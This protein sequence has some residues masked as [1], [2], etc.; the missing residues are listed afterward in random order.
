M[1][2]R[3]RAQQRDALKAMAIPAYQLK[4][5]HSAESDADKTQAATTLSYHYRLGPFYLTAA[6]PLPVQLP[7]WLEDCC[8]LLDCRPVAVKAASDSAMV[9]DYQQC[10]QQLSSAAGKREF[11]HNI[12]QHITQQ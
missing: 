9:W 3:W 6:E 11:W 10:Q 1:P 7:R 5:L 8:V 12:R 4:Q 2:V